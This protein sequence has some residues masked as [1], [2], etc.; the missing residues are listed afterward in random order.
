MP[1]FVYEEIADMNVTVVNAV[2]GN[3]LL[4]GLPHSFRREDDLRRPLCVVAD[5]NI[6]ECA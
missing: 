1:A 2:F 6:D 5:E 4:A 3:N